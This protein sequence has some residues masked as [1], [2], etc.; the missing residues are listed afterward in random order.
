[1]LFHILKFQVLNPFLITVEY[2]I[3][4][5]RTG[6]QDIIIQHCTNTEK[7]PTSHNIFRPNLHKVMREGRCSQTLVFFS[8]LSQRWLK[9]N[10]VNKQKESKYF[11]EK[12]AKHLKENFTFIFSLVLCILRI[13]SEILF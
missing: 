3:N 11:T 2:D 9:R 12:N 5:H 1:M 7:N 8:W 10:H 6:L 4:E 13:K